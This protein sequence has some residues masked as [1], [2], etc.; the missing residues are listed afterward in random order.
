MKAMKNFS[1]F[2]LL[3]GSFIFMLPLSAFAAESAPIQLE[4]KNVRVG[5]FVSKQATITST[6]DSVTITKITINRGNT[7]ASFANE[8]LPRTLKFGELYQFGVS[9]FLEIEVTTDKGAWVFKGQ[10]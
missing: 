3:L 9:S 4:V 8:T 6:V 10:Q 1:A 5:G 7:D 2:L